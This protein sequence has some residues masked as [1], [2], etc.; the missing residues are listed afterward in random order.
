[1]LGGTIDSIKAAIS[2]LI[3][4]HK[5]SSRV[6]WT[7]HALERMDQRDIDRL[8]VLRILSDSHH[9][10]LLP[11]SER[12]EWKCKVVARVKANRDVG[13]VTVVVAGD[14][15]RVITVQWEDLQ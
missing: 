4:D 14:H 15:I 1:M 12:G 3:P 10:E 9:I 11:S 8:D 6:V 13:V 5:Q 2:E 7:N